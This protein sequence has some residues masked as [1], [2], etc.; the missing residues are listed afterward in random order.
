M[1]GDFFR[2][3]NSGLCF[4][5]IYAKVGQNSILQAKPS[6]IHFSGFQVGEKITRTLVS[7]FYF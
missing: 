5:E 2:K 1:F 4:A 6:V 3:S 7:A